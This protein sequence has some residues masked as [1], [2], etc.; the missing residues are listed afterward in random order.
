[1]KASTTTTTTSFGCWGE[2]E[3]GTVREGGVR[4]GGATGD[5]GTASTDAS[6]YGEG[7]WRC[8]WMRQC[9]C[10]DHVVRAMDKRVTLTT[11]FA[12]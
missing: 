4:C 9:G 5:S 3:L 12:V 2:G 1:M 6:G 10:K 7:H 8:G 11:T